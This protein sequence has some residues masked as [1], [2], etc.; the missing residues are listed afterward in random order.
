MPKNFFNDEMKIDFL[1]KNK[2]FI[3]GLM[4]FIITLLLRIWR[5]SEAPDIHPDEVVYNVISNNLLIKGQFVY[6]GNSTWFTHPPLYYLFLAGYLSLNSQSS[7]TF[8]SLYIARNLSGI[9][10]AFLIIVNFLF[11]NKIQDLKSATIVSILLIFDPT[12]LKWS[13]IGM[14]ESAALMFIVLTIYLFYKAEIKRNLNQYIFAG[15]VFG[16]T[17]LTKEVTGYLI[18][19][20]IIYMVFIHYYKKTSI[21]GILFFFSTAVIIYLIYVVW[22]ISVDA[23][24]FFATKEYT[25]KR[26]TG[27]IIETGYLKER[28]NSLFLDIIETFWLY[29]NTHILVLMSIPSSIYLLLK[30]RRKEIVLLA[31]WLYISF[32]FIGASRTWED[33][34]YSYIT[35]PSVIFSGLMISS[36]IK[37]RFFIASK[38]KFNFKA[39]AGLIFLL[40]IIGYN[41]YIWINM[42]G[43]GTD[44]SYEQAIYYIKSNIPE[45][46]KLFMHPAYRFFLPEY[47]L[48]YG[49]YSVDDLKARKI[50]YIII[51]PRKYH[52]IKEDVVDYILE[53][54]RLIASFKGHMYRHIDIYFI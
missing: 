35:L 2:T 33:H 26:I 15:I 37:K 50:N 21:R 54:G 17:L 11:I 4:L 19:V 39:I 20:F 14:L 42:Y 29:G 41:S 22:S 27:I 43:T 6:L 7:V 47:E 12:I 49:Y 1:I 3:I 34:F 13:R 18:L 36:I 16:L 52:E 23:S 32:F 24:H 51:S 53:N 25:L 38:I 46:S 48:Y 45:G 30:D 40:S 8:N 31:S 5:I 28:A 10:A 44:T 9:L